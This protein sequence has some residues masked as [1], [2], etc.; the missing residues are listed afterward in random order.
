MDIQS[1]LPDVGTSIFTVMSA[2]AHKHGA[3]NLSQGFPDFPV[4]PELVGLIN[5]FM[6]EGHN[7]YAPMPGVAP[8][9][10]VIAQMITNRYHQAVDPD[11]QVTITSGATEALFA[12]LSAFVRPGDE[13]I[14]FDPSYDSYGPGIRL[15]GGIPVRIDLTFPDYAT[16]WDRVAKAITPRTRAIIINNPHNPAGI[17]LTQEDLSQLERVALHHNLIVISDEVYDR[18]TF[19]GIAHESVLSRPA[20]ASQSIAVFSFGKTFHAT[21]WKTGYAVAPHHLTAEIRKAHQFIVFSVNAA[22]QLALAEYM[23]SP[24]HYLE[25]SAFYQQKRDLFLNEMK[26]SSFTP[27]TCQGT[28]FQLM[29][30][31]GISEMPDMEMAEA[32]TREHKVAA[33][34]VS[35]FYQNGADNKVLRFCFAKRDETLGQAAA[36]LRKI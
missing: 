36:I 16:D 28:Y 30:Y 18:L 12:S 10:E 35:A 31:E 25:L 13:V 32:L 2:L 17:V 9:R 23:K 15:N 27:L 29:A 20:L 24:E 22:V 6:L 5:R 7:Q 19:D 11:A 34:P 14:I 26:G 3:I 21:G 1:R 8:L 33:I 4:D